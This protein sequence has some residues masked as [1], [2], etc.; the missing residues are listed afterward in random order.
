MRPLYRL[1]QVWQGVVARPLSPAALHDIAHHLSPAQM[2]LFGRFSRSDQ[3]HSYL[4]M[5]TL[6]DAGCV[7]ADLLTAALLHD[8]GKTKVRF[9]LL[10]RSWA[11]VVSKVSPA[12]AAVW[13]QLTWAQA[14]PW[15]RPLIAYNQHPLWSAELAAEANTS[16]RALSLIRRH[17]E[18][19]SHP[20]TA[21][22]H[23]LRQLQWADDQH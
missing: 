1:Q 2:A 18:K 10:A 16:P 20:Q 19:L 11:A 5:A 15:Q 17:Q 12:R 13:G 21:E 22:D 6:R 3:R 9:G 7:E 8:V 4:V 23:L 14:R